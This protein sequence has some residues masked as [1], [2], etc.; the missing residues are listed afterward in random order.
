MPHLSRG[1]KLRTTLKEFLKKDENRNNLYFYKEY[2][3]IELEMG[4]FS[5]CVNILETAIQSQGTCPS[6]ITNENERAALFSVYRTFIETLLD[7]RTYDESHRQ[8]ILKV[9]GQMIPGEGADQNSLV[10]A[11]LHGHVRDF[12]QTALNENGK[13]TFFLSNLECDMIVCYAYFLYIKN[14]DIQTVI[15]ILRSCIDHSKDCPYLQVLI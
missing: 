15:E 4:R 9:F 3:L 5:N 12:L 10:E 2:A 13:D 6:A 1:K 11:Y 14:D 7:A 8:W